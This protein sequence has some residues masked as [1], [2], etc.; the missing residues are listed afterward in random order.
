MAKTYR[1]NNVQALSE[2]NGKDGITCVDVVSDGTDGYAWEKWFDESGLRLSS[3]SRGVLRSPDFVPTF[4]ISTRIAIVGRKLLRLPH[5]IGQK[6]ESRLTLYGVTK[7]AT[8]RLGLLA[9]QM[10]IAC[11]LRRAVSR[12]G[13][14]SMD[15]SEIL[16]MHEPITSPSPNGSAGRCYLSV[17]IDG[18]DLLWD[19][20][21]LTW[22]LMN[23]YRFGFAFAH[24]EPVS[25]PS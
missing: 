21:G 8:E 18:L 14:E 23:P 1:Q 2:W 17:T 12:A 25:P 15:C 5:Y 3:W 20:V 19:Y 16:V 6:G 7:I 9:P 10:E 4:G 13:M 11:L 22:S 24:S